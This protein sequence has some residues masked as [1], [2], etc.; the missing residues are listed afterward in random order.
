LNCTI[1]DPHSLHIRSIFPDLLRQFWARC[2]GMRYISLP[3]SKRLT[4]QPPSF[5]S[6]GREGFTKIVHAELANARL[7]SNALS[8][9]YFTVRLY[10]RFAFD[11]W[12]FK[13]SLLSDLVLHSSP[14]SSFHCFHRYSCLS[15]CGQQRREPTQVCQGLARCLI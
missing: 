1:S 15:C 7:F 5:L 9:S 10:A 6:L 4:N 12:A 2:I 11:T 3:S 14:G 13:H 8:K